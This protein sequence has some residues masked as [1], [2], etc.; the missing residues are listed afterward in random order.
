MRRSGGRRD[1]FV[2]V[3]FWRELSSRVGSCELRRRCRT[4]SSRLSCGNIGILRLGARRLLSIIA[5][6]GR[7]TYHA[8]TRDGYDP[9]CLLCSREVNDRCV[10]RNVGFVTS[11]V[12][13]GCGAPLSFSRTRLGGCGALLSFSRTRSGGEWP[14]ERI[15]LEGQ[16]IL[17]NALSP[18][19]FRGQ[20]NRIITA[21]ANSA[22]TS[23]EAID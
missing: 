1:V 6:F 17:A 4:I 14:R 2:R 5:P 21:I 12:W 22:E 9:E 20:M 7:L 11:S 23:V 10:F 18:W 15:G 8:L 3:V 13:E 19:V 16:T